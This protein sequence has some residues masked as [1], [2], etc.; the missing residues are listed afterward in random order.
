MTEEAGKS[1]LLDAIDREIA[2]YRHRAGQVF[3]V[4]LAVEVLILAGREK[5]VVPK[6]EPWIQPL[7]YG[8]LFVAV[9]VFGI[10]L[11]REYRD[12]IHKLKAERR[13]KADFDPPSGGFTLSEIEMLYIVLVFLSS[14]G[15]ILVWVNALKITL[16]PNEGALNQEVELWDL[17]K[18]SPFWGL[19]WSFVALGGFGI[20]WVSWKILRWLRS[21]TKAQRWYRR[22]MTK[23]AKIGVKLEKPI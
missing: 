10:L 8:M 1:E 23:L 20:L 17:N 16:P 18:A 2:F 4:S 22:L 11:G 14:A 5:I 7:T 12:R 21:L 9:A 15:L 13:K 19:F 3:F 6:T